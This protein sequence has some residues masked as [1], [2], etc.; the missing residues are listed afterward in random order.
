MSWQM[1]W[2]SQKSQ[3]R[4]VSAPTFSCTSHSCLVQESHH[5]CRRRAPHRNY[6]S[7]RS[8]DL[9]VM[10][11]CATVT[12]HLWCSHCGWSLPDQCPCHRGPIMPST[13][14]CFDWR[15]LPAVT[16]CYQQEGAGGWPRHQLV[17]DFV[18]GCATGMSPTTSSTS[19]M[20]EYFVSS[21]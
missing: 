21:L 4:K 10:S 15:S 18:S 9:S 20:N 12:A 13:L 2:P 19:F 11:P 16:S 3:V 5:L 1:T 6:L 14:L 7:D 17:Q 8:D